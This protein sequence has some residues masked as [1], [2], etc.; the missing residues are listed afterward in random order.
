MKKKIKYFCINLF[1]IIINNIKLMPEKTQ[2]IL[3]K[4]RIKFIIK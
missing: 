3:Y 4:L 1:K 2:E